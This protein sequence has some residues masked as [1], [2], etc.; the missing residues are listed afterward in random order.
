MPDHGAA[1]EMISA[2]E[3]AFFKAFGQRLADLRNAQGLTQ[4]Q[5]AEA[6]GV[7]QQQ[8]ASYEVGRRRVPLSMLA[9]LAKT[10]AVGVDELVGQKPRTGKRGPTPRLQTKLE[11]ISQLPRAR[12][13]FVLQVLDSVL[14]QEAP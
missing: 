1:A 12:Q 4:A 10:L 6:L 13:R 5:M 2:D 11:R 7:S 8:V 14:Q 3:K 9:T